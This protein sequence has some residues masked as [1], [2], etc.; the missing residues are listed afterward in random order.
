MKNHS[1][2]KGLKWYSKEERDVLVGGAGGIGSHLS[3]LL[4]RANFKPYLF[5]FDII[6]D[7][8]LGGQL[9]SNNNI[10]QS[11]VRAMHEFIKKYSNMD[12]MSFNNKI[13]ED[14]ETLP[15]SFSAFD[16]ML[17]RKNLFNSWCKLED[18]E[19]FIDGRLT[20]EQFQ[21]FFVTKGKEDQYRE[22]LFDDNSIPDI[23]C[24]AKQTTH[25]ATAIA[26]FMVGIFTNFISGL[27]IPFKVQYYL[28]LNLFECK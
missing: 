14:F 11:K 20:A 27:D 5:D 1:R 24:T 10:G 15:I 22:T 23:D 17:A 28:P 13:K 7:H 25:M 9:F 8:N 21:I 6:E 16:N 12:I 4:S 26:S 3:F 2:F 19:I 18:R